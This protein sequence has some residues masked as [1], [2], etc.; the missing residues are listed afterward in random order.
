MRFSISV[1]LSKE[2]DLPDCTEIVASCT[3]KLESEHSLLRDMEALQCIAS[4]SLA[5]CHQAIDE[6]P[7]PQS[8]HDVRTGPVA[9]VNGSAS[10]RR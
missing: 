2:T 3:L 6:V 10:K 7:P 8:R 4:C 1:T 9:A 5:A